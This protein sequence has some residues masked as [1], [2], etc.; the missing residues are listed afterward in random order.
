M[1]KRQPLTAFSFGSGTMD[2][3]DVIPSRL[4]PTAAFAI[5]KTVDMSLFDKRKADPVR[6][7]R[8]PRPSELE[9]KPLFS[10]WERDFVRQLSARADFKAQELRATGKQLVILFRLA[11]RLADVVGDAAETLVV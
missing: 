6:T 1:S 2:D 4:T 10:Q 8:A 3:P 5:L 9:G 11:H 7:T